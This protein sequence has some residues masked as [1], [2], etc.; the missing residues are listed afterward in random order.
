[1]KDQSHGNS[2]LHFFEKI[3]W[4]GR[5]RIFKWIRV[6]LRLIF[7]EVAPDIPVNLKKAFTKAE[8]KKAFFIGAT[9]A[10]FFCFIVNAF[11]A[12]FNGTLTGSDENI[13]YFFEDKWNLLLYIFVCPTYVGFTCWLAVIVIK[14][15]G[16]IKDFKDSEILNEPETR[17]YGVIKAIALGLL[18]LSVAFMLTT[19]YINDIMTLVDRESYYWFLNTDHQLGSLGIYYFLLNFSLLII[20]LIALVFFMTI[21]KLV[22]DIGKAL[23]SKNEIGKLEFGILKTKLF[24]FTEAY[25]VTKWIIAAYIANIWIWAL[26]PLGKDVTDNFEIAV[27]LLAIIGLNLL[28]FPRLFVELQWHKLK[29]RSPQL[30]DLRHQDLRNDN[31]KHVVYALDAIFYTSLTL[32][33]IQYFFDFSSLLSYT[34]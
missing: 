16:D 34:H 24:A 1:M 19:N 21:Y 8:G 11:W 2:Q 5:F 7:V 14:A 12:Y 30:L 13:I 23:S 17:N 27:I 26:S 6:L 9:L 18:V 32:G 25:M 4:I 3:L 29:V 10:F 31:I 15:W 22:F 20:T 33:S 28:S